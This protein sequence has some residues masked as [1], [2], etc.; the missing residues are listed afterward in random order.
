MASL[1]YAR[2]L[3]SDDLETISPIDQYYALHF[4]LEP[5]VT[6]SSLNF[7]VRSGHA[8]VAVQDGQAIGFLFAQAIWNGTRP[9]VYISR[10][11]VHDIDDKEARLALLEAVTKSAYDAAVYDL[12][13]QLPVADNLGRQAYQEKSY[14]EKNLVALE[15]ILGSRGQS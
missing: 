14:S 10:M 9:A 13:G 6:L 2:P 8:F 11:A 4:E 3:N 5:I 12:Q 15:R 7:F 1:I